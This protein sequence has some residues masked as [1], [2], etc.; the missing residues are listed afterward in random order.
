MLMINSD[1]TSSDLIFENSDWHIQIHPSIKSTL[2][3]LGFIDLLLNPD[4]PSSD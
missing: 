2:A 3:K 1:T 4:L